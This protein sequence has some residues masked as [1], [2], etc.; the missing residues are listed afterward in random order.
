MSDF[1]VPTDA[2]A[3]DRRWLR[4]LRTVRDAM[5]NVGRPHRALRGRAKA[6]AHAGRRDLACHR[7]GP[8]CRP[9]VTG[10]GTECQARNSYGTT[11]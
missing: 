7:A 5:T 4:A 9:T 10:G 1:P 2:R 8:L 11:P 6:G 3:F